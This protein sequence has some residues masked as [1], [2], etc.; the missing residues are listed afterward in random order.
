[1]KAIFLKIFF[2]VPSWV[3][4]LFLKKKALYRGHIFDQQSQALIR[5]QPKIDLTSV[6]DNELSDIRK[7]IA[8]NRVKNNLS[9]PT[10]NPVKKNNHLIGDDKDILLREYIPITI[11]TNKVILFFHG[12][13]Y[14]LN[15]VETHDRTVSY[16]AEKLQARFY[17]LEYRLSP[18]HKYPDS[19]NDALL[20]Y[21]W[22]Q[23][24]G[25]SYDCISLCGDSA[26][27]HLAASM[28][29][30]LAAN[31]SNKLP[32]SQLLIY[33]M[34]DPNCK[35][36]SYD[37]LAEDFLLTKSTMIWFWRKFGN[38][39]ANKKDQSFNLLKL[40]TDLKMPNTIIVTAGFDPL[41]DDGEKYAY[42]LHKKGDKVKQLH[43]PN[44]FHGFASATK[45]K[46]SRIAVD[47]FLR[48]YKKI[49]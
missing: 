49:L 34:C 11:N 17:S 15:S 42:L 36:E 18:E 25:H 8:E 38:N 28:V 4:K 10:K 1:V 39:E 16:M 20:A 14:V 30:S 3:F 29:H 41:C 27:A 46:A 45:L 2:L 6:P 13:G 24:H 7:L 5:L 31:Q 43:Y 40:D 33:P 37:D 22:L 32:N 12:G 21:E 19:L 35:S 48:E 47:D 44:M 9:V 23:E 26:G